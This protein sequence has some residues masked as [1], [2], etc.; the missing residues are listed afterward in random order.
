MRPDDPELYPPPNTPR[1]DDWFDITDFVTSMSTTPG[2]IP[3][4]DT[5]EPIQHVTKLAAYIPVTDQMLDD[6]D[7]YPFPRWEARDPR[8][9]RWWYRRTHGEWP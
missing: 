5:D 9:W 8:N 6:A 4:P 2:R 7:R 1:L 3:M